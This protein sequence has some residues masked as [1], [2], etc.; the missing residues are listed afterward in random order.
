MPNEPTVTTTIRAPRRSAQTWSLDLQAQEKTRNLNVRLPASLVDDLDLLTQHFGVKLPT[1]V[2]RIFKVALDSN[3][4]LKRIK[5]QAV[6]PVSGPATSV[7]PLAV[8]ALTPA[9]HK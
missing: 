6:L 7:V 5:A 4:D 3:E 9:T 1:L 8:S 2:E